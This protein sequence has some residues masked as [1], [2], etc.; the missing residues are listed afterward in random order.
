[1]SFKIIDNKLLKKYTKIWE[2][3]SNLM[4]IEFVSEP[5]YDHNDKYIKL[6]IKSYGDKVNTSFLGNEIPKE[7]AS[8][9]CWPLLMLDSLIIVNKKYY[10]ETLLEEC[11]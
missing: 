2:I 3:V 5:I 11:K 10:S 8:Y 6:R 9:K 7:N 4:N 1:M